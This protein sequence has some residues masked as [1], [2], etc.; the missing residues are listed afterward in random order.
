[1]ARPVFLI[2]V[3]LAVVGTLLLVSEATAQIP[4]Q[5]EKTRFS[6][7]SIHNP[8]YSTMNVVIVGR[9]DGHFDRV[10]VPGGQTVSVHDGYLY[11]GQRVVCW[12]SSSNPHSRPHAMTIFV[13]HGDFTITLSDQL[14]P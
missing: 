6:N 3:G 2:A 1:M 4:T 11:G 7:I 13:N 8:S 10:T 12:W 5:L 9:S 14:Q